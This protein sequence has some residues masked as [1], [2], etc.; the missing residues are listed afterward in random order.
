MYVHFSSCHETQLLRAAAR[1]NRDQ[2][3]RTLQSHANES[4][5]GCERGYTQAKYVARTGLKLRVHRRQDHI[6]WSITHVHVGTTPKRLRGRDP[7]AGATGSPHAH[8]PFYVFLFDLAIE[9]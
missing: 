8:E 1:D 6:H 7:D 4:T 5:R 2:T 9:Q 3:R